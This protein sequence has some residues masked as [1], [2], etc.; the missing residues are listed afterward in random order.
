MNN[1]NMDQITRTVTLKGLTDLMFDRFPGD[2]K[3][4]LPIESKMYFMQ[5]GKSLC[6][7]S[8]NIM[9]FLSAKNTTSIAKMIAGKSWSKVCD[10]TLSYVTISPMLIPIERDGATIEFHGFE[11]GYDKEAKI[12]VH[13][14]VARLKGGIPNPKER[15]VLEL[16]WMIRLKLSLFKNAD[17][18]EQYLQTAFIKGG[19]SLGIG[20]FRGV[21]GKFIVDSW[22]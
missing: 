19:I 11:N 4:K 6:I 2:I 13:N 7:P 1:K 15:P 5:D 9:S 18:D 14:S 17:I 12:Y 16:P 20:T 21:F 3:T 22:E 10:A 8:M